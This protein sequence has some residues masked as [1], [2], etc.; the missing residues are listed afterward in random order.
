MNFENFVPTGHSLRYRQY[1]KLF[2]KAVATNAIMLE[3]PEVIQSKS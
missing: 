3:M 2:N 1:E